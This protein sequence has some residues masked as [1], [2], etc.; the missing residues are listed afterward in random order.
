MRLT[1][2][3]HRVYN[4]TVQTLDSEAYFY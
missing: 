4:R 3:G 1:W 2:L